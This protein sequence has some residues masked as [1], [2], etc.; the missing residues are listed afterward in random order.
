MSIS[1]STAMRFGNQELSRN[2]AKE[3]LQK[4]AVEITG[5]ETVQKAA[6]FENTSRIPAYQYVWLSSAQ[7]TANNTL[8]ET[9]KYLKNKERQ[10]KKEPVFGELWEIMNVEN[11]QSENNPYHGDLIDFEID[12]KSK[13]IFAA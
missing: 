6:I 9:I 3:I 7:I 4:N 1:I 12:A 11:E 8:K 10:A 2:N 13:N 5:S